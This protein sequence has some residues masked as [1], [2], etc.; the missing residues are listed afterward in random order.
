MLFRSGWRDDVGRTRRTPAPASAAGDLI[1]QALDLLAKLIDLVL[2]R[3]ALSA[4]DLRM[5][6]QS[7]ET[8]QQQRGRQD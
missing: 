8:G 3:D 2:Q 6:R 5:S 1:L 4:V 7:S